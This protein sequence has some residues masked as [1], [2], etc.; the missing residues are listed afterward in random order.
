[1]ILYLHMARVHA[2]RKGRSHSSRPIQ[3]N[4]TWVKLSKEEITSMIVKMAKDGLGPSEIGVRLRDLHGIPLV[5][6]VI[7]KSITEVLEEN[8]IKSS[9]P[10]DLSNLLSKAVRLQR[11]LSMHRGD[12]NNIRSLELIEAKIHRLVKYY[13]REGRLPQE[14]K[15][16]TVIAQLE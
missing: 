6:K 7:G 2:H 10:E 12:S 16:K 1:M 4:A 14:W 5:K 8:G 15:Y 3:V 11:H 9:T 13:K